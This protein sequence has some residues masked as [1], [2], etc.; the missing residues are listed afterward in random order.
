MYSIL[1]CL[2]GGPKDIEPHGGRPGDPLQPRL[3]EEVRVPQVS[4]EE[5]LQRAQQARHQ[6]EEGSPP[7]GLIQVHHEQRAQRRRPQNQGGTL[8]HCVT[9]SKGEL[10]LAFVL[11][12]LWIEFDGEMGLDYGGVAREWFELLSKVTVI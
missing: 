10:T 5:T 4:A 1:C 8:K 2:V 9:F 3:Q 6:S 7:R 11:I 12:Q